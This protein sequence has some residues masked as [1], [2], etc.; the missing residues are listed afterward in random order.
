LGGNVRRDRAFF[1]ASWE[2]T[3]ERR[4]TDYRQTVPTLAE[5]AGDFRASRDSQ[6]A[7]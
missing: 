7:R 1:F 3:D 2:T 4:G 6:G 5:R